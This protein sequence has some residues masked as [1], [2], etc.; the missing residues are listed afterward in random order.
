MTGRSARVIVASNRAASGVYEDRTGPILV[1]WLAERGYKVA[2]PVVVPDGDPVGEQLRGA[3][4]EDFDLVLTT[5]GTGISPSDRTPEVTAGMLDYDIPG[6][7]D[8]VRTSGLP[9]VPT[10]VLSRGVAGVAGSTLVVNLPGSRGGVRDGLAVLDEVLEH[11]LDQVRGGD[12][13]REPAAEVVRAEVVRAQVVDSPLSADEHADAV[14]DAA[15]GAVVTFAGVVRDHDGG[16]GVTELEYSGHPSADSVIAE[17]AAEV[18]GR[19][20]DV[21][22]IAVSHRIGTLGIGDI[23]LA[24]AVAG[25]HRKEAFE[26]CSTLVDEVKHRLPIWKRQVFT[27]GTEEWVNCP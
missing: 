24:A 19:F 25:E 16:R 9:E 2:E 7:A 6:L 26:A 1:S 22:R 21:R 5:G 8:A 23:A 27:D 18:A 4:A 10:A 20:S 11:A 13:Q 14:S 12:H 15:S 17:V 3:A